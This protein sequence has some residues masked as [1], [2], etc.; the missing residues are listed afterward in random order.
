MFMHTAH[1]P[2][3]KSEYQHKKLKSVIDGAD[4]VYVS[5]P[6]IPFYPLQP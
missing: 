6:N 2:K 5:V 1:S 3:I 4:T